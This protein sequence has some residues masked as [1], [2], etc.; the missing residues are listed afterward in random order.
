MKEKIKGIL[1]ALSTVFTFLGL[2]DIAEFISVLADN[3]EL[4]W[5]TVNAIIAIVTSLLTDFNRI[6]G[7]KDS[8]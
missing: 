6:F 8:V 5:T 4:I 3:Y 2:A 1:A 7:N